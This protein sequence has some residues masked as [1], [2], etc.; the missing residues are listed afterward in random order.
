MYACA[1]PGDSLSEIVD[2][3]LSHR[4]QHLRLGRPNSNERSN[5]D[6]HEGRGCRDDGRDYFRCH[7]EPVLRFVS[8]RCL[9]LKSM[10]NP[11][12]TETQEKNGKGDC[13]YT[14]APGNK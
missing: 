14:N 13:C 2:P 6:G 11:S 5:D 12:N 9:P 10:A 7:V 8:L 4:T 1:V 3:G